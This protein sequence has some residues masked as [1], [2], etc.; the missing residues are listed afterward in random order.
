MHIGKAKTNALIHKLYCRC[1]NAAVKMSPSAEQTKSVPANLL[2]VGDSLNLNFIIFA[3]NPSATTP[4]FFGR[5]LGS[6]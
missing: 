6:H 5:K 1:T 3:V 2:S 4:H